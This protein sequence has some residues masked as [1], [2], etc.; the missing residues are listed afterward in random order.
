MLSAT[1]GLTVG[2]GDHVGQVAKGDIEKL[3]IVSSLCAA[4]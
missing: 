4:Q 3:N 2:L 1:A